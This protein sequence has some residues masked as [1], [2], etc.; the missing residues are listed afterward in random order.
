M[1]S[2]LRTLLK[3]ERLLQQKVSIVEKFV[4][5]FDK[6]RDECEVEVRLEGLEEVYVE[7]FV[8]REKIE[9]LM[10][11]EEDD[12]DDIDPAEKDATNRVQQNF[13][14]AENFENRY[15]KLKVALLKLLPPKDP[16]QRSGGTPAEQA[17][18]H[19]K[20]KLPEI[21]LPVF[22]GKLGEWVMFRDTFR[23]LIHQNGQLNPMD[24]FTYL[25]T[26]LTGDALK[27]INTIELS[28]ANYE[29]A[30]KVLQER[31]ENKKLIV[32]A[33]LDALFSLEP[34]K[35]ESYDGLN[36]LVSEFEKNLQML[37]K[38][39]EQTAQWS[40]ILAYMLCARMDT[41]TLRLWEAH[42]NSKNVPKY[43]DLVTFLRNQC[44]VLQSIAPS[45]S[46][47]S[48]QRQS[49]IAVCHAVVKM[50]NKC[51][52]CG[53]SWHSPFHC[54][55]FQKMKV[56]ER[57]EAVMK[58]KLCR[59]C[60]HPGHF[61]RTCDKGV[62]HHCRQK[63]HTMLHFTP[64]R[65]S[66]PP[67]QTRNQESSPQQRQ[68]QSNPQQP[69]QQAHT[70]SNNAPTHTAN[71]QINRPQ[72]STSQPNTSHN[73]VALPKTPTHNILLSTALVRVKDRFGNIMLARALLD[74]CSQH[75]LMTRE[76]SNKLKFRV[77]P[78]FLSVQGIGS[79]QSVSTKRVS[80]EVS[81]RSR[82]ISP[83]EEEMQFFV[84]PKLTVS[85]PTSSFI[86]SEWNLPESTFMADPDFYE[87]GPVDVIIGAEYYLDLLADGRLKATEN[88]PTLQNTVFGWIVSGRVP[89]IPINEP[90]SVVNVCSTTELQDQ[91]TKFWE[92]ETCRTVSNHSVEESACEEIFAKTTVR[93][94]TGRF[95]V[96]L[97]KK[98]YLVER[99]GES[100][101]IAIRRLNCLERR[102]SVNPELRTQ[103]S[104][105]IQEYLDMG[106]MVEV[107]EDCEGVAYYMP[108]H[109]V[110]K[111]ESTTTKLRVV[112][113][114]S[115]KTSTGV[116]LNEAL[117]VGPVVQDELININLRFRLHRFAVVADVAKMYRMIAVSGPDRKLQ[118][119][120]WKGNTDQ[121][122]RTF[123]LATVTYGTA[124]APY[125]ATRCLV[126]LAEEE[127]ESH[128]MAAAVLK[129][130]FYVDDMLSGVDEI[131]EGKQFVEEMVDLMQSGGFTLRKWNSN[132]EEILRH[133]PEHLRDDRTILTL[134][135]SDSTVKTLGLQWEPRTDAY[136][137][138]TPKWN[139]SDAVTKRTVLSDISR[140]FDPLGLI[141][142]VIVQAK[143]FVQKLWERECSWDTPLSEELRERWL[144]YRR[145]MIGL[146]GITVPRWIGVT[147]SLESVELHGFCDASRKAYGACIYIRTVTNDGTVD[148]R[149]LTAKS[150]VAP[151]ENL[152]KKKKSLSTPR[153]ELSS[154]LLLAHLYEKVIDS[155]HMT[156]ES[157]FWTDSTIVKYWLASVPSRWKE[158]VS[159][160]V[161]E[162]QH[163]TK[164]GTWNHVPGTEN[165]ADIIS[166]GMAPPQ[167]Q[168]ECLW[169]HGPHWLLQDRA[170]WPNSEP[171]T[172]QLQPSI[173][174][175]KGAVS[176]LL[177]SAEPSEIFSR[178]SSLTDLVTLVALLQRF[179]FNARAT[180]RERRKQGHL[181]LAERDAALRLLVCLA[182]KES[183][184]QEY[185][186]LSR[187]RTV[188]DSS[189]IA[190]LN[191]EM[192]DGIICV[193]GRLRNAK[194]PAGRKHPYVIDHR[195]PF[196]TLVMTEYHQNLFH[197]GQQLLVSSVRGKYWPTNARNVA[198]KVIHDCVRCFRVKPKIHEQLM[199]DLPS[200]RVTPCSPFQRVGIDLCGPFQMKYPQRSARP[201]K[202]FVVVFVCLVTK[203]VHLELV[204]DQ[205][206]QAFLAS[207]RRFTS[208]R[209]RPSLIM[210]DNGRNFIGAN[211]ELA[212]LR[213][214]FID[215]QFQNTVVRETANDNIEFR[216]IPARSPNFGGLW[217][218]AVKSF[219]TLLKRTIGARTLQYDEFQTL[220]TQ[221]EAI[222]NSRPLTP[223]SNDPS[224]Y[225]A[226]TPGHFLIQRPLAAI[227]EPNLDGLPENRLSAW[228]TVQHFVQ[229]L[230]RK[231]STQYLSNLHN[232]TKWTKKRDNVK[233]GTMVVLK[234]ENQPPL[235]WLLGRI[236]EVHTGADGNIRVVTVRTKD[237][238]FKRAIS[239]VCILPISDNFQS[240]AGEN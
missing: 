164:A 37:D 150:R 223:V 155:I 62:C 190:S 16:P 109:A 113:D 182:Q 118:R 139:E 55:K 127:K 125:L 35:K 114:A 95:I 230:W 188:Q 163:V 211:R 14:A 140:L 159:N 215:Q 166:R 232:R 79:A 180:N 100:R 162:I 20:V 144:E 53:E 104:D 219:K 77:S 83:F 178:R 234:D 122:I 228:Q 237:G 74:S 60:L 233:V 238:S 43:Q 220:L 31:Y 172:S 34:L 56:T 132:S 66:V 57:N 208:R 91:L 199:A 12:G 99:L 209:G 117:M 38:V 136:R 36:H 49:K 51:P 10:E 69:N 68:P 143:L 33:Y 134:D 65:S 186:E 207:L 218:S 217:E 168:Y 17:T 135:S 25:R 129:E 54:T 152:K 11:D 161:S 87:S 185:A 142:P 191:P 21:S 24:K 153:L 46:T 103:Y 236:T 116:S 189:R 1:T 90:R 201:V 63:H 133:V 206:S 73:Y 194:V 147:K 167:L 174:E 145:N 26:S 214:L 108:H 22:S 179:C 3:R 124:S 120:V 203:A 123:E 137:F 52:F 4:I 110:L 106:H 41:V 229:L 42:H 80:A 96:T 231:W 235:S 85:L 8:L 169:W 141:G 198:R 240:S 107:S 82:M 71:S 157:H 84:L 121:E 222:L 45:K 89:D 200:E 72:P 226:L 9:L 58:S 15:C 40:T 183:F 18:T 78:T 59:N 105:F 204:A 94:E 210:C 160:R 216:F 6:D 126:Q 7:F 112:F 97:P 196:T 47:S 32:K 5:A 101:S 225:E 146:D 102:L 75:C 158:F 227:P 93:D 149:L 151:L 30:W 176:A 88:G 212:E 130:D 138:S 148:V 27:E 239:K 44:S 193:G 19:S 221:I 156:V 202:C 184:P 205:T 13:L 192:V 76:F 181:T 165:P 213:K 187:G 39:G 115:C 98:D 67:A 29:V 28:A 154:A 111:P 61:S 119:I 197:A 173:L 86:P 128:P 81:P 195:H 70:Q 50:S 171:D 224:D 177:P 170:N 48:D 92:I 64:V 175:E 23:S 2:D 131:D